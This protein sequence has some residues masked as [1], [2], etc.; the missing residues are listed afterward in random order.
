[1][2][3]YIFGVTFGNVSAVCQ[4]LH[5]TIPIYRGKCGGIF[6]NLP[7]PS[8]WIKAAYFREVNR[9]VG[10]LLSTRSQRSHFFM[11]LQ[12]LNSCTYD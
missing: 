9:N 11:N 7:R 1:M 2:R 3:D 10:C 6:F 4:T 8:Q 12:N 5:K